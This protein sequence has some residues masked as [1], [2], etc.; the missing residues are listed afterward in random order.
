MLNFVVIAGNSWKWKSHEQSQVC[1]QKISKFLYR[2]TL[3]KFVYVFFMQACA[4]CSAESI[5]KF[6]KI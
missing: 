6:Q 4:L 3:K 5:C 2:K 1:T